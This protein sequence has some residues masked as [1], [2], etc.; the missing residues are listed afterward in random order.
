MNKIKLSLLFIL[1]ILSGAKSFAMK[2]C[3]GC[4]KKKWTELCGGCERAYYCSRKCA[5]EDWENGHEIRC[6]K[7][8]E[9]EKTCNV[10]GIEGEMLIC[11]GCKKARYCSRKCQVKDWKKGHKIQ[12]TKIRELEKT[13]A[14]CKKEGEMHICSGC[15]KAR[16]C[17]RK[18]QGKD[19]QKHKFLC[20]KRRRINNLSLI[21][22]KNG[23]FVPVVAS[24]PPEKK[25]KPGHSGLDNKPGPIIRDILKR[26]KKKVVQQKPKKVSY[27]TFHDWAEKFEKLPLYVVD[28][29]SGET[30]LTKDEFLRVAQAFIDLHK[31]NS[32]FNNKKNWIEEVSLDSSFYEDTTS[33]RVYVE[34]RI[35][36]SNSQISMVVDIHGDGHSLIKY[37]KDLATKGYLDSEN[38]FKINKKEHPNF[39]LAFLGDYVDRGIYG[40]EVLYMIM[41]LKIENP[42]R[43]ILTRGNHE[44]KPTKSQEFFRELEK[45]SLCDDG[46]LDVLAKVYNLLPC[47]VYA[48]VKNAQNITNYSLLCHAGIEPRFNSHILLSSDKKYQMMHTLSKDWLSDKICLNL[49]LHDLGTLE[50]TTEIKNFNTPGPGFVEARFV[51]DNFGPWCFSEN[52]TRDFLEHCSSKAYNILY[53]FGG[54]QHELVDDMLENNGLY[55]FWSKN[56]WDGKSKYINLSQGE[57]IWK[58]NT[59]PDSRYGKDHKYNYLTYAMLHL[60]KDAKNWQL[61]PRN[62]EVFDKNLVSK[63]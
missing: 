57:P 39:Y 38:P 53:M 50:E 48:G 47:A 19:W 28:P 49:K 16:Y 5:G 51:Q 55:N 43:V 17:S 41:R 10:C 45:K 2:I 3:G 15:E 34:K 13:C 22:N 42:D 26:K 23:P 14:V 8:R 52:F 25:E 62:V 27:K 12:C 6:K 36:A 24:L 30:I 40:L 4:N 59:M 31:K 54:H 63:K 60:K 32:D 46:M 18:C 9:L 7:I 44:S 33:K 61:E 56:Q 21:I 11:N 58:L 1:I 20:D 29:D 37:L 35:F